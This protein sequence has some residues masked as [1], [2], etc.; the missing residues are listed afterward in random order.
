MEIWYGCMIGGKNQP[1]L[2]SIGH[3]CPISKA[4]RHSLTHSAA[5]IP[6]F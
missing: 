1:F 5:L 2:Y 4:N 3:I 6:A